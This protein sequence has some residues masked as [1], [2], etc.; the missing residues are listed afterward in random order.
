MNANKYIVT[1][2]KDYSNKSNYY[3]M[4]VPYERQVCCFVYNF[5]N[6]LLAGFRITKLK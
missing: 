3:S 2:S 5:H 4:W 1:E 6:K